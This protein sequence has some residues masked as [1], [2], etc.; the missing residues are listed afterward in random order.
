MQTAFLDPDDARWA[1]FLKRTRHDVYHRPAYVRLAARHEGGAPTAFYAEADDR[2]E[3]DRAA[4][5]V[6][7]VLR[8]LP[9]ALDAP[10][11]WRDAVSPYGYPAPLATPGSEAAHAAFWEA[12]YEETRARNLVSVFLRLHPLLETPALPDDAVRLRHGRTVVLDLQRAH[13]AYWRTLRRD[14]RRDIDRLRDEGFRARLDD[15]AHYDDFQQIYR[16]TMERVGASDAYFFSASY[17]ADF[18]SGLDEAVHLCTVHAPDEDAVAAAGLFTETGGAVQFHL[19]GSASAYRKESPSKL[20]LDAV[21]RWAAAQDYRCLHLGG[22]VGGK[23]DSLFDFK[24][25]FSEKRAVF[26]SARLVLAP[27]RYETL[28]RQ[29]LNASVPP[30]GEGFFPAYRR[31]SAS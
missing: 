23:E 2:E 19:S 26:H 1:A 10:D 14:H 31:S 3:G 17:F 9:D 30:P 13:E 4:F 15:W 28:A 16:S 20:M 7:L 27:H 5:L 24:I 29:R 11:A 25:G 12:F 22:G 21:R 6:P 8:S 18:R